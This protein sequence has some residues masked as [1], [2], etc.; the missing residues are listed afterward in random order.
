LPDR[1]GCRFSPRC[2][3]D[4]EPSRDDRRLMS[5]ARGEGEGRGAIRAL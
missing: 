5:D 3:G 1:S 4:N 2:D